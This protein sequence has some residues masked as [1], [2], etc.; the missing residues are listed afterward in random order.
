[1]FRNDNKFVFLLQMEISSKYLQKAVDQMS[2]LPGVGKKTALRLVLHLIKE[3][4][5]SVLEFAESFVSLVNN[6]KSCRYCHNISDMEVCEICNNFKRDKSTICVVQDIRDILAIENTM[7][8]KGLYH[9]LGG[10]ISPMEGIGPNDLNVESLISR[11]SNEEVKEVILALSATMEGDTTNFYLF[12]KLGNANVNISVIARGI[13]IGSE[14][15]FTD[16]VTLG[17]SITNR[18]PF[19]TNLSI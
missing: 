19:E 14:L 8:Y 2:S 17:R 12:K 18:S 9:V 5:N 3:D 7:Q 11:A 1:V 13:G 15:E 10:I 6:V 4:K 16:E